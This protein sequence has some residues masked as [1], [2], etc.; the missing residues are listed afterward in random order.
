MRILRPYRKIFLILRVNTVEKIV[1]PLKLPTGIVGELAAVALHV[2]GSL[3][4]GV[5]L[6]LRHRQLEELLPSILNPVNDVLGDSMVDEMHY[7]PV[8]CSLPQLL[9]AVHPPG[10]VA[11]NE[12]LEI[13]DRRLWA[14]VVGGEHVADAVEL[15]LRPDVLSGDGL[16]PGG[17]QD[18]DTSWA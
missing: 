7:S 13:D 11:G 8:F 12:I 16:D 10:F 4:V 9:M 14:V 18:L 5:L 6:L 2:S 15:L 3:V 1:F 17:G